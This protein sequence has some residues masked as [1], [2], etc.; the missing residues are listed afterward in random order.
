MMDHC[1]IN[2]IYA[3]RNLKITYINET[4][5]KT[6]QK[7]A[8]YLPVKVEQIIGHTIGIF[9]KSPEEQRRLLADPKNLPLRF[10]IEIGPEMIEHS[11]TP[12][13]IT[14]AAPTLGRW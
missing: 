2:V 4:S 3:D 7:P 5:F 6:L 8:A 1:P 13:S 10:T 14:R 12:R 9:H 11:S